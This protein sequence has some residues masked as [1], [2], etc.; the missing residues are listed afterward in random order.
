MAAN[1]EECN[2]KNPNNDGSI[3][4]FPASTNGITEYTATNFGGAMTGDL[5][6]TGF[7]K[8]I[9]RIVLNDQGN[10]VTSKSKLV[11]G[12]GSSPLDVWAQ[13]DGQI[14]PGT[15]WMVDNITNNVYVYEPADYK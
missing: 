11:N 10:A 12:I 3:A 6:L 4:T 2:Y 7:D 15:F 1:P 14:F 5:L 8:A 9:Y 13:G